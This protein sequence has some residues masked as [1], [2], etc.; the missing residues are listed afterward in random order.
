MQ[1]ILPTSNLQKKN[2]NKKVPNRSFQFA[3]LYDE[4]KMGENV[5]IFGSADLDRHL[6]KN[7]QD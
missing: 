2:K 6:E 3:H 4:I 1:S 5:K 7:C